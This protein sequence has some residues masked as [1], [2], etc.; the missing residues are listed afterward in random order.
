[1]SNKILLLTEGPHSLSVSL[2][3][4]VSL[5]LFS[6]TPCPSLSLRL[7]VF[8]A[9]SLCRRHSRENALLQR[10]CALDPRTSSPRAAGSGPAGPSSCP[11]LQV[12]RASKCLCYGAVILAL[13]LCHR[14]CPVM[15]PA[16]GRWDLRNLTPCA[17]TGTG[18][19][20]GEIGEGQENGAAPPSRLQQFDLPPSRAFPY[21]FLR[22]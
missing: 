9:G 14:A 7:S 19:G 21:P 13:S 16:G 2:V 12:T 15:V 1:M 4:T 8:T 22:S 10:A 20:R 5:F 17:D 18:S 11:D 3:R 6:F